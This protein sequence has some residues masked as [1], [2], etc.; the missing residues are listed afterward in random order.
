MAVGP[1]R[2]E[3]SEPLMYG[4]IR[5]FQ[6]GAFLNRYKEM[7]M[8]MHAQKIYVRGTYAVISIVIQPNRSVVTSTLA[9]ADICK[10]KM[11]DFTE[12]ATSESL[13]RTLK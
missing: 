3:A 8:A 10:C 9:W 13:N 4:D 5:V 7:G 1:K 6:K 2:D 12:P 11:C